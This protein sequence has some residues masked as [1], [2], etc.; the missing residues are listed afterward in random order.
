MGGDPGAYS[1]GAR[2]SIKI[3]ELLTDCARSQRIE[4]RW[5]P[6]LR[7]CLIDSSAEGGTL[8][9]KTNKA[10]GEAAIL[11]EGRHGASYVASIDF[12]IEPAT[13]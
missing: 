12:V 13:R 3:S 11:R 2:S 10:C 7:R 1:R 6:T 9:K 4:A 5:A 8:S